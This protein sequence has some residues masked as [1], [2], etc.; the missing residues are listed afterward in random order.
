MKFKNL[1]T[2]LFI[3]I[4]LISCKDES[5]K[6]TEEGQNP[7]VK[8]ATSSFKVTATLVA[9]KDDDF[10]LLYTED[11]SIN[12]KEGIWQNIKGSG[13]EQNV[14]FLLPE[15]VFPTQL[16]MDLGKNQDEV[17]LKSVKFDYQGKSR[18][19]KGYEL[20]IFFRPDPTKCTYDPT[21]GIIKAIVTDG[22]IQPISLYPSEAVLAK[23]LPKLK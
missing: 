14:E 13:N 5:K 10:C 16:R 9:K 23:E 2:A 8:E 11:G 20:G 1:F 6:Q 12:F 4:L 7:E 18:E 3:S 19:V 21:L 15:N 17:L 22:K